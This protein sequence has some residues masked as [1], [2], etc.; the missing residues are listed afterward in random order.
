MLSVA[1]FL[2]L[3]MKHSIYQSVLFLF[4]G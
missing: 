2:D 1:Y 4:N 3:S